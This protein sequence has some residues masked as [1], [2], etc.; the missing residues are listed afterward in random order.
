MHAA[1]AARHHFTPV[2]PHKSAG[3]RRKNSGSRN[4]TSPS[5]TASSAVFVLSESAMP[6]ATYALIATGGVILDRQA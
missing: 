3:L 2:T 1:I 6:L 5:F 4:P